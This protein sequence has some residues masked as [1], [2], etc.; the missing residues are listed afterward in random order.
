[1]ETTL[2]IPPHKSPVPNVPR[3]GPAI[4][5]RSPMRFMGRKTAETGRASRTLEHTDR[6]DKWNGKPD[7]PGGR[8]LFVPVL[9]TGNGPRAHVVSGV[10]FRGLHELSVAGETP[11]LPGACRPRSSKRRS[12]RDRSREARLFG[13]DSRRVPRGERRPERGFPEAGSPS[14]R[15][16]GLT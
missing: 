3:K 15:S 11:K 10:S 16:G 1:M 5:L 2:G 9:L 14:S 7:S 13:P 6:L 4:K 8:G 12:P